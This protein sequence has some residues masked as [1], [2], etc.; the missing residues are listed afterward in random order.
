MRYFAGLLFLF[1]CLLTS[2]AQFTRKI[3]YHPEYYFSVSTGVNCYQ[4]EGYKQYSAFNAL[5]IITQFSGG[6][7]FDP[8]FGVRG[9]LGFSTHTWPD[10]TDK[11]LPKV[12]SAENLT[13][14]VTLN[15]INAIKGYNKKR[16]YDVSVFGGVGLG[17]RNRGIYSSMITP[18][19]RAG[20][21]FD[22][23]L[24][25]ELSL[26]F[27]GE[28][29]IVSTEFNNFKGTTLPIDMYPALTM[30]VSYRIPTNKTIFQTLKVNY[31]K[32]KIED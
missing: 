10:K 14:D 9:A 20:G 24:S 1:C 3:V 23:K 13:T 21:Q 31:G 5:G 26:N 12:I 11:F 25:K 17:F 22:Y 19:G 7:N 2:N 18:I 27:T 8:V 15:I 32:L 30:G 6:Y 16:F 4:A 29:N 28:L